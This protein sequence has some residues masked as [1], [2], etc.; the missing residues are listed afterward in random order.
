[1]VNKHVEDAVSSFTMGDSCFVA[2][3]SAFKEEMSN[4]SFAAALKNSKRGGIPSIPYE[5]DV[6]DI[7]S[8]NRTE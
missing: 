6:L 2:V 7:L 5:K 4:A 8:Y 1:M 3:L